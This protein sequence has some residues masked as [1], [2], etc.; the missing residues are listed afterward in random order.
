MKLTPIT[1]LAALLLM[2]LGGFMAGRISSKNPVTDSKDTLSE[3]GAFRSA[4]RSSEGEGSLAKSE[5]RSSQTA[6]SEKESPADRIARLEAIIRGENPLDRTRALLAF[7]DKL[8]PGDFE[9]AVAHFRS[10]GITDDRMGEYSMLLTA[11]AQAD[12]V[13]ALAYATANTQGRFAS[14][15]IL[16]AWAKLDTEGAI[17]WA[18]NHHTGDGANPHL[19]GIIRGLIESSPSRATELLASMPRSVERGDGLDY[20]LP[21]LWQ[22]GPEAVKAWI[23]SLSDPSL[24]NGAM[25]RAAEK[26][27]EFDPAGTSDWLLANE[28]SATNDELDNVYSTWSKAD[29]DASVAAFES[30][31]AGENRSNALRGLIR[32]ATTRS[33][34]EGVAL[35]DRYP[36]DVNDRVVQNFIWHS[37]EKDPA[38]AV[39]QIYRMTNQPRQERMYRR[40]LGAWIERDAKSAQAWIVNHQL[41]QA[42]LDRLA[43]DQAQP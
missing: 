25:A 43:N 10:L 31:P 1:A 20:I 6:R 18:K 17:A 22:Q 28:G 14:D 30:I 7:I 16:T 2:A 42:V 19:P 3:A 38:T 35:M 27:A 39:S 32:N 40:A 23:E 13:A 4:V 37:F 33:P 11:W 34:Q 15:T 8:A 9:A 24:R 5:P 36:N 21:H 41:P 29:F 12:P 26:L